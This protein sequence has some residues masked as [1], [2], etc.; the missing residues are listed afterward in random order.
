ML[1][2]HRVF[3][4]AANPV[5]Q[6]GGSA[7]TFVNLSNSALLPSG[8]QVGDIC[9]YTQVRTVTSQGIGP[10]GWTQILGT[11]I[12]AVGYVAMW[13]RALTSADITQGFVTGAGTS[14]NRKWVAGFRPST[15]ATSVV[16]EQTISQTGNSNILETLSM[17]GSFAAPAAVLAY[18]VNLGSSVSTPINITN[19]NA[20]TQYSPGFGHTLAIDLAT[21]GTARTTN[22]ARL[23]SAN[24]YAEVLFAVRGT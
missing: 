15:P 20:V 16:V 2:S 21:T 11:A 8:S 3:D 10:S 19:G 6:P 22:S 18:A 7:L 12:G 17:T 24:D 1:F 14:I 5:I 13:A 23:S 4:Y 9:V